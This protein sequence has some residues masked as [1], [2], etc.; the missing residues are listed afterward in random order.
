MR[1][2][3]LFVHLSSLIFEAVAQP[4]DPTNK[5]L[6]PRG[7][8]GV[9]PALRKLQHPVVRVTGV[10]F[11]Y[12]LVQHWIDKF[13]KAYPDIQVIIEARGTS[14]PSQYDIL[15]EGYEHTENFRQE[16]EYVYVGRYA[17][18]PVANSH[19]T[20]AGIYREKGL[21]RALITQLYFHD[22][23]ADK[24]KD[25]EVR[26]PYKVYTRLQKAAAPIVFSNYFGYQQ[27][28]IKG[29]SIAGSDEHLMK[30]LVR[31]STGI[32]YAP[33]PNIYD[34]T[35]Q[36]V[37]EGISIIPVDLNGNSRV[38]D[39]ERF[40][41]SLDGVTQRLESVKASEVSNLPI[42]YLHFSVDI[43]N[44]SSD[45]VKFLKWVIE[46]SEADLH[47]FGY[48]KPEPEKVDKSKFE[49]FAL[50]HIKQ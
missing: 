23:Y 26:A 22:P 40:Y 2:F 17:V 46:N 33:V 35:T 20:F 39:D 25:L 34:H 10:R 24:D 50:K 30:A 14:D 41:A 49:Q 27:K 16:R 28:D 43:K 9:N 1:L 21:N 44:V 36:Q 45:A 37:I 13:N 4:I 31:D 5:S 32:S 38:S 19:S 48:L 29:K 7:I 12:P 6:E 15:V 11:S 47:A 8:A 3:T 42:A 18:L